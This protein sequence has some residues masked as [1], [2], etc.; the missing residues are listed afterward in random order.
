MLLS[1]V[2]AKLYYIIHAYTYIEIERYA[3]TTDVQ[4]LHS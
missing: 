3:N 2:L 1:C 4:R